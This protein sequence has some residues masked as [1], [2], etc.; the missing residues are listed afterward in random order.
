MSDHKLIK[1]NKRVKAHGEVFT[2]QKI[3]DF[4][5]NQPEISKE[6]NSLTA[7]FFEPAAGEGA[8]LVELLKKKLR[9][10]LQ[11]SDSQKEY[12][13]NVLLALMSLY[14]VEL[15]QDNV[16]LLVMN[17]IITFKTIYEQTVISEFKGKPIK[18]VIQSAKTVIM[19]NMV[20]G[21]TLT[22]VNDKGE[23][24]LFSEWQLIT[25]SRKD[26][27]RK[28]QRT[29]YTLEAILT[30]GDPSRSVVSKS[31]VVEFDLLSGLFEDEVDHKSKNL[32]NMLLQY[33]PSKITE[34]YKEELREVES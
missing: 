13:E 3:V 33:K 21:N 18:A 23:P 9:V 27:V 32:D 30:D 2:P 5:V 17:M 4:M 26:G 12:D 10:A 14:G 11:Q 28:I 15:L 29:E 16:E 6:L 24:L 1:S 34:V 20:Q 8:F 19:A 31:K 22:R 25:P 7:T